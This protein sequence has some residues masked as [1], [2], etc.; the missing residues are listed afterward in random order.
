MLLVWLFRMP[1]IFYVLSYILVG[2]VMTVLVIAS[3]PDA[4]KVPQSLFGRTDYSLLALSVFGWP[5]MVGGLL[6]HLFLDGLVKFGEWLN[7]RV[8]RNSST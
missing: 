2:V 6:I 8:E 3:D 7:E 1:V 4:Y 5:F